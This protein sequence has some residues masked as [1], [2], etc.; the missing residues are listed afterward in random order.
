MNLEK[1]DAYGL[2]QGPY[3]LGRSYTEVANRVQAVQKLALAT[4]TGSPALTLLAEV[5]AVVASASEVELALHLD[6]VIEAACAFQ[7]T[8][9]G[10]SHVFDDGAG[11]VWQH[12]G[13]KTS[14][15]TPECEETRIK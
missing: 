14:C 9:I 6:G 10:D 5:F 11:G 13:P 15:P 3:L 2:R 1:R 4:D 12:P 7:T 8:L